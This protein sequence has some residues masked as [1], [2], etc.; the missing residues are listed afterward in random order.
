[1][2][3]LFKK[4]ILRGQK[5]NPFKIPILSLVG[6]TSFIS[7]IS[8]GFLLLLILAI[9]SCTPR[10][11]P[12]TSLNREPNDINALMGNIL[13]IGMPLVIPPW[14]MEQ[15]HAGGHEAQYGDPLNFVLF[16]YGI[17]ALSADDEKK[18]TYYIPLSRYTSRDFDSSDR[19]YSRRSR[20][21]KGS[22]SKE[23]IKDSTFMVDVTKIKIKKPVQGAG[24]TPSGKDGGSSPKTTDK[25]SNKKTSTAPDKG[26]EASGSQT[27]TPSGGTTLPAKDE[28]GSPLKDQDQD[29][30]G[31]Q[32]TED[33]KEGSTS[34]SVAETEKLA[35]DLV[36][37]PQPQAQGQT[38]ISTNNQ[39][40]EPTKPTT[41]NI[42]FKTTDT[43]DL[44]NSPSVPE[45][46]SNEELALNNQPQIVQATCDQ[47][48]SQTEAGSTCVDCAA[49]KAMETK[50]KDFLNIVQRKTQEWDKGKNFAS[51][52]TEFCNKCQGMVDVGDFFSYMEQRAGESHVPK[53]ILFA[54]MMRESNG[55][56]VV[57]GDG[58][59]SYGLFQLNLKNSTKLRACKRDEL[60]D[61]THSQM[62]KACTG[63]AYRKKS[64]Y[65]SGNFEPVS[66]RPNIGAMICLENPYCN[67]EEALHLLKDEKWKSIGN[68]K[69]DGSFHPIPKGK[70]SWV[71]L[72]VEE[73][74][75]WRNAIIAYNGDVYHLPAKRAMKQAL[76][77]DANLDNWE[78]KR[79]FFI[80]R[81][82]ELK[83]KPEGWKTAEGLV[84]N[85]AYVERITGREAQGGLANSSICK[86]AKF[87]KENPKPS[88]S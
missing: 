14:I 74:N 72:T 75:R 42:I 10:K 80:R 28:D 40:P 71:D 4:S 12:Q 19:G 49:G 39:E 55:N 41:S 48:D 20:S 61:K 82:L 88:C 44:K 62:K 9:G 56:C 67:F 17:T 2:N 5:E 59:N 51:V 60:K 1:M 87:R 38:T 63:G 13:P 36:V 35:R 25:P 54:I 18:E 77:I 46:K 86:W 52:I 78:L 15:Y 57:K 84:H 81:Y 34:P 16:N 83:N 30:T 33:R 3:S 85:L 66:Q 29:L 26:S 32:I 7:F 50:T 73:R 22:S 11:S 65:K 43:I 6:H 47:A 76:G 8:F 27:K 70:K 64:K 21:S 69:A 58:D 53:E 79:M 31:S 24:T 37:T 45:P 23:S 68:K